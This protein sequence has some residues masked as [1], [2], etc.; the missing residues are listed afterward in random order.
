MNSFF[1]YTISLLLFLAA[2]LLLF[3]NNRVEIPGKQTSHSVEAMQIPEVIGEV[4]I[5]LQSDTFTLPG[6]ATNDNNIQPLF[7]LEPTVCLSCLNNLTDFKDL[8]EEHPVFNSA[9][10]VFMNEDKSRVER[11]I[12][13]SQLDF[14]YVI[15]DSSSV[16]SKL[17][18]R[19][20]QKLLFLDPE[21]QEIFFNEP[22]PNATTTIE[23]KIHL[24]ERV[25]S[26]WAIRFQ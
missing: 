9:L 3:R 14:E 1:K 24:L 17:R 8:F 6:T 10:L 13:T 11:F 23:S 18:Q 20:L 19:P 25:D 12:H 7:F 16:D 4:S 5:S 22:I 2:L 15:T 26:L 21:R